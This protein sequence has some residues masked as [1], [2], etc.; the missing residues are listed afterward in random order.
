[1][2][3][4]NNLVGRTDSS[5]DLLVPN[6]LPYYGNRLGIDDR[7]VPL[8]YEVQGIEKTIAPPY[9][10][11]AFVPFPVQQIRTVT[12]SVTI[13]GPKGEV[14]PTFG[15]LTLTANGK[16][17]ESPLGR[18]GEFYFE[19]IGS[20]TYDAVIEHHDGPCRFHIEI[21]SGSQSVVKLGQRTCTSEAP[22]P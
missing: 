8:N 17:Y 5:G 21:P 13:R 4:S 20:G 7:D 16:S 14:V 18:G 1:V 19:N 9:R 15:Q 3:S 11:G 6:L 2:Y 12:G 22:R 10:G